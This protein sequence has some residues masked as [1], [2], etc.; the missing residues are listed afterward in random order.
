MRIQIVSLVI[1]L[2]ISSA[3]NA[4]TAFDDYIVEH[5]VIPATLTA[6]GRYSVDVS[7]T[8]DDSYVMVG[9][10]GG[11]K[12]RAEVDAGTK[13]WITGK[14]PNPSIILQ[15]G[16]LASLKDL[17]VEGHDAAGGPIRDQ[18]TI[19]D[20]LPGQCVAVIGWADVLSAPVRR[21][22]GPHGG[23][24]LVRSWRK[25]TAGAAGWSSVSSDGDISL[26][27]AIGVA[28]VDRGNAYKIPVGVIC[29]ET[30]SYFLAQPPRALPGSPSGD[31][32]VAAAVN[33]LDKTLLPQN[34]IS[35]LGVVWVTGRFDA[36]AQAWSDYLGNPPGVGGALT[37]VDLAARFEQ[38]PADLLSKW[39]AA[40][41]AVARHI[42]VAP[43]IPSG[44]ARL[45]DRFAVQAVQNGLAV[46][47]LDTA[48][49]SVVVPAEDE[50]LP[51]LIQGIVDPV[52][53]KA[54][55]RLARRIARSLVSSAP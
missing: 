46:A 3:L 51:Y 37:P 11:T 21:L 23:D 13:K 35:T 40:L 30:S 44:S 47:I 6:A 50:R 55:D 10:S 53:D 17:V 19:K 39:N 49:V 36:N 8:S 15:G 28:E 24:T 2:V 43:W 20:V 54:A 38:G 32:P 31:V 41:P 4:A 7:G 29:I 27:E 18:A 1:A 34:S 25:P 45:D 52:T 26:A 9:W 12:V 14:A 22:K 16:D 5:R 42:F 48:R 33:A